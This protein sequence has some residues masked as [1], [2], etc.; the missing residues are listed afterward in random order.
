[1]AFVEAT[2]YHRSAGYYPAR[3]RDYSEELVERLEAGE[4]VTA[5]DYLR[6]FDVQ[7]QVRAEFETAFARVEAI[8]APTVPIPAPRIDERKLRIGG[9]EE[10]VRSALIR[11][12]RPANFTGL[13]AISLPCGFTQQGLPIGLQ[14]IGRAFDEARV[15]QLA[16]TYEQANPWRLRRPPGY[17]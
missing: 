5:V 15:L 7:K 9:E 16:Y 3:R 2:H 13:P 1:M 14:I 6:S 17:E 8:V 10:T 12:N 11:L 4:K